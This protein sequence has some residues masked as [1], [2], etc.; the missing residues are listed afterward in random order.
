MRVTPFLPRPIALAGRS[1]PVHS[2]RSLYQKR[3]GPG[4]GF[5]PPK[6]AGQMLP[7]HALSGDDW[8]M[9]EIVTKG[10]ND[11]AS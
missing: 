7:H 9:L 2:R 1:R 3:I 11:Y 4:A 5:K 10:R 6:M 8:E